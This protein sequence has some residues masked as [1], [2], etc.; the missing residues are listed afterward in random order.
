MLLLLRGVVS[1]SP[2]VL[3]LSRWGYALNFV[4]T[5]F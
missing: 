3:A 1:S 5:A 4:L 2:E